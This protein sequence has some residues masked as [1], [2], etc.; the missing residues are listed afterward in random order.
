MTCCWV[1]IVKA[2][3][4]V[5][6]AGTIIIEV[7]VATAMDGVTEEVT[8]EAAVTVR[9]P[10]ATTAEFLPGMSV[11]SPVQTARHLTPAVRDSASNT[12]L[13]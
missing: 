2:G 4:G 6:M 11:P 3:M 9:L 1:V 10:D 13:R 12:V 8:L 5:I 7:S